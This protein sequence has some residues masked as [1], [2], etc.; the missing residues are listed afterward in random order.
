LAD[1]VVVVAIDDADF[2]SFVLN[3]ANA[4][5]GGVFRKVDMRQMA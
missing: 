3:G 5:Q 2:G 4:L 1:G